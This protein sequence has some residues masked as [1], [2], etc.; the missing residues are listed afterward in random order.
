MH[1]GVAEA[2]KRHVSLSR[3]GGS[4][5][6]EPTDRPTDR[7]AH[8]RT[9]S[10]RFTASRCGIACHSVH[11]TTAPAQVRLM[12]QQWR[13]DTSHNR[14]CALESDECRAD[15]RLSVHV[16]LFYDF[17]L[18][19]SEVVRRAAAAASQ[20]R[21]KQ[22]EVLGKFWRCRPSLPPA[23]PPARRSATFPEVFRFQ[24]ATAQRAHGWLQRHVARL[25]RL[26]VRA[27]RVRE[28]GRG[29][30]RDPNH[31]GAVPARAPVRSR[32][33]CSSR[34]RWHCCAYPP[35]TQPLN[36]P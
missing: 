29:P 23:R 26:V 13:D 24:K 11:R 34:W 6:C 8:A 15:A 32:R 18:A 7:P 3:L 14:R 35:L 36:P 22:P 19:P 30:R 28:R 10:A 4:G 27:A 16:E 9:R 17:L 33:H 1:P 21:A 31:C 12:L 5:A 20:P 25:D 2:D